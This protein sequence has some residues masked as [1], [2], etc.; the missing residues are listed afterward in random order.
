MFM[1]INKR[2]REEDQEM[3]KKKLG[4][5][6]VLSD[7]IDFHDLMVVISEEKNQ[8]VNIEQIIE[9]FGRPCTMCIHLSR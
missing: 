4:V 2:N 3:Y 5:D 1:K 9:V 8:M 7:I 6:G